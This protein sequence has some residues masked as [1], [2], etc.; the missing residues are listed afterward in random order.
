MEA[1][2]N[3]KFSQILNFNDLKYKK[4]PELPIDQEQKA[5]IIAKEKSRFGSLLLLYI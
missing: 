1:H 4:K 5:N 3:R 2:W